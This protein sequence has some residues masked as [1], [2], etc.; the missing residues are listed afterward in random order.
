MTAYE[1][2]DVDRGILHMLQENARDATIE[3][4]GERVGVSASTVRN[5]INEMEAADIIEGYHP[6]INYANA[7]YDLHV[8]YLCKVETADRERVAEAVLDVTGVVE[9]HE[10]LD[11]EQNIIVEVVANDPE[12]MTTVHDSL[13]EAGMTI[14]STEYIRNAYWQPFN[15]FGQEETEE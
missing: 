5:R 1:L 13:I 4:M 9:V 2:D 14:N 8:L 11:S 3:E 10:L 12:H 15:H 7:G 6:E